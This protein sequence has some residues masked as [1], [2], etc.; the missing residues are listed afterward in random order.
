[1]YNF[2]N[3]TEMVFAGINIIFIFGLLSGIFLYIKEKHGYFL[4]TAIMWTLFILYHVFYK[5]RLSPGVVQNLLIISSLFTLI[6]SLNSLFKLQTIKMVFI[7]FLTTFILLLLPINY[8]HFDLVILS[9]FF[10]MLITYIFISLR[11][12]RIG[13]QLPLI[14][15]IALFL[16]S[17]SIVM[18]KFYQTP[19]VLIVTGNIFTVIYTLMMIIYYE[20]VYGNKRFMFDLLNIFV[21]NKDY[22]VFSFNV[23]A[24]KIDYIS[25]S[26][27]N[28]LGYTPSELISDPSLIE[29]SII[30]NDDYPIFEYIYKIAEENDISFLVRLVNKNGNIIWTENKIKKTFDKKGKLEKL[31]GIIKDV[32]RQKN[33][34]FA[35]TTSN[36][37]YGE[38]F[39]NASDLI[40][41]FKLDIYE[42]PVNINDINIYA[43]NTLCYN[44]DDITNLYATAILTPESYILLSDRISNI[45]LNKGINIELVMIKSDNTHFIT[46]VNAIKILIENEKYLLIIARDITEKNK[47]KQRLKKLEEIETLSLIAGGIAHDFNNILTSLIGDISLSLLSIKS[48]QDC[49]EYLEEAEKITYKAKN[50]T[51]QLLTFSKEGTIFKENKNINELIKEVSIFSLRGS[52]IKINFIFS[53]PDISINI[54]ESQISRV[55]SNIVINSKQAMASGG[56]IEIKTNVITINNEINNLSPGNY[57]EIAIQD[58]GCGIS[59]E[60]ID[61]IFTPFFTTKPDGNGL[62]LASS[63]S[64]ITKHNGTITLSSVFGTGATFKIY[65]PVSKIINKNISNEQASPQKIIKGNILIVDDDEA[66]LKTTGKMLDKMGFDVDFATD[67]SEA[68]NKYKN[69]SSLNKKYDIVIFDLTIPGGMGGKEAVDILYKVD[70][71][72]KAIVSSGYSNDD[73][74]ANYRKYHFIDRLPKPYTFDNLKEAILRNITNKEG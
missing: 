5:Y 7:Y 65:L 29:K 74:M 69:R 28:I 63:F 64:I 26:I 25:E 54:D 3:V 62:G 56:T 49:I 2:A 40:I 35:L 43:I 27:E 9:L 48:G 44:R 51:Q 68:I 38:L 20:S 59:N 1:M 39:N 46:D 23:A 37:K 16:L 12:N 60:N 57:L 11:K 45:G 15:S 52:N 14:F 50:L 71:D 19:G 61:K 33:T 30:H 41:V 47:I 73:V 13:K 10:T 55:I 22:I 8:I 18:M 31:Q 53:N 32:T 67:G 21:E 34:E 24:N 72:I 58:Q 6:L 70:P 17:I 42:R 66:I 4:Y 36:K